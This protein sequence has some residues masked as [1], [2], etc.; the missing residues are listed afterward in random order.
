MFQIKSFCSAFPVCNLDATIVE[1]SQLS[2]DS[3]IKYQ[4]N[5]E[6]KLQIKTT[7]YTNNKALKQELQ[8]QFRKREKKTF[9][10]Q[11]MMRNG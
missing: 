10:L 5:I 2:I 7:N 6:M 8:G 11:N 3:F 4:H 1:I 9:E